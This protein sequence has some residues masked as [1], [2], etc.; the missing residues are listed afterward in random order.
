P[1]TFPETPPPAP[2]PTTQVAALDPAAGA[3][4]AST[5]V[6]EGAVAGVWNVSVAGQSCRVATPRT[7]FGQGFRAAPLR[8]PAPLDGVKSW[9][10]QGN[11]VVLYNDGGSQVASLSSTGPEKF[12]GTTSSGSPVSL[13]R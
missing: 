10:V 8:C 4:A 9:A 11:Q 1:T 13:T 5:P 6:T 7:K 12:D 3:A 2:A